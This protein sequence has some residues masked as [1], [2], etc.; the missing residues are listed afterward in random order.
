MTIQGIQGRTA[1][2]DVSNLSQVHR[3]K[4][5]AN[6]GNVSLK[7]NVP[8]K[9]VPLAPTNSNIPTGPA[10]V[11]KKI[12]PTRESRV[13]TRAQL[14]RRRSQTDLDSTDEAAARE[15]PPRP[16]RQRVMLDVDAKHKDDELYVAEY[17]RD[18]FQWIKKIESKYLPDPD[19]MPIQTDVNEKMRAILI[20]WLIEVHHK[21]KLSA[22]VLYLSVNIVDRY[23]AEKVI[24]RKK[25]QLVG[26][27]AM[28]IASK[29]EEIYPPE[30]SDFEYIT[31]NAYNREEIMEME[32]L[33]LNQLQFN[34]SVP[35]A[36]VFLNRYLAAA[37]VETDSVQ[38]RVAHMLVELTLHEFKMMK[39][40]PSRLA[41]SAVYLSN[42][43]FIETRSRSGNPEPWS[44]YMVDFTSFTEVDIRPC[45][46]EVLQILCNVER[47]NMKAVYK[48]YSKPQYGEVAQCPEVQRILQSGRNAQAARR[49]AQAAQQPAHAQRK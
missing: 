39:H 42:R 8:A 31:D 4:N 19:Y 38:W 43:I 45:S 13:L 35:T 16:V 33:I 37:Q 5:L 2:A 6:A 41:C 48:K 22:E 25:L 20:D 29:Y 3:G 47:N 30:L 1:L 46:K 36:G 12:E 17:C 34:V 7:S 32:I 15:A 10:R 28:L 24:S 23:L 49:A 9:R 11:A 18:I 14:R 27:T 21:F 26:V 40:T 44:K